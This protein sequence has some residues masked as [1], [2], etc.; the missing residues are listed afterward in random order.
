[1]SLQKIGSVKYENLWKDRGG[2]FTEP[3]RDKKKI[4]KLLEKYLRYL[5]NVR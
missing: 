2:V 3:V 5:Q 1:M 4:L